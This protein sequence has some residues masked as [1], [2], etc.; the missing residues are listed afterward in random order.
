MKRYRL[1]F[2]QLVSQIGQILLKK[3]Q[4]DAVFFIIQNYINM[5]FDQRFL[6]K[7]DGFLLNSGFHV[8]QMYVDSLS[9]YN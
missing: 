1:A 4:I 7:K 6:R 8:C 5:C 2:D 3:S 9:G